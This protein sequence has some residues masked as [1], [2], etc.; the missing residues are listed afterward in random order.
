MKKAR[1][2]QHVGISYRIKLED[3]NDYAAE[4]FAGGSGSEDDPYQIG[5]AEELAYLSKQVALGNSYQGKYFRLTNDID[6]GGRQWVP[7]GGTMELSRLGSR[8]ERSTVPFS[9]IFDGN[10]KTIYHLEMNRLVFHAALFASLEG[11]VVKNL[12]QEKFDIGAGLY[13][14]SIAGDARGASITGC[15]VKNGKIT[16]LYRGGGLIASAG[17]SKFLDCS[18][19][20]E[21]YM[22]ELENDRL[23]LIATLFS[24]NEG[25]YPHGYGITGAFNNTIIE[26]CQAIVNFNGFKDI[27][28]VGISH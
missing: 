13:A 23:M 17:H 6:L 8:E 24:I 9:G 10:G 20:I 12:H 21:M 5:N 3:W 18:V 26:N 22:S 28:H 15:R 1:S 11:A 16:T 7:I 4:S 2:G 25:G 27:R 19:D 14:G